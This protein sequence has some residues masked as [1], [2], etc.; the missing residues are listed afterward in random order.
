MLPAALPT[1][2][3][4]HVEF[5][6]DRVLEPLEVTAADAGAGAPGATVALAVTAS[7]NGAVARLTFH[8]ITPVTG[9]AATVV[10]GVNVAVAFDPAVLRVTGARVSD[11]LAAAGEDFVTVDSNLPLGA[12]MAA[13]E[14]RRLDLPADPAV[15]HGPRVAL[16]PPT[17]R[18]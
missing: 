4:R 14:A 10:Q 2:G 1:Y 17:V 7:A 18:A 11:A 16:V 8:S 13:E 15:R 5:L 3:R 6:P 12:F 9:Q